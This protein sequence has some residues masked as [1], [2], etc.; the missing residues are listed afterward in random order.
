MTA[1]GT[2]RGRCRRQQRGVKNVLGVDDAI[3]AS[4]RR[5]RD[6]VGRQH[7]IE[8]RISTS[9]GGTSTPSVLRDRHQRVPVLRRDAFGGKARRDHARE[10]EHA[11][12]DR[13]VHRPEQRAEQH[14]RHQ[15]RRRFSRQQRIAVR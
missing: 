8:S 9:D 4:R 14:A 5:H 15:R 10:P 7:R 3:V 6:G 2:T 13:T 11:G 1:R 12:A